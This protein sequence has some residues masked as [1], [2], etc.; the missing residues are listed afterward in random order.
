MYMFLLHM[1][2][3]K[4][5][6][7][8]PLPYDHNADVESH[9]KHPINVLNV[10]ESPLGDDHAHQDEDER[11]SKVAKHAPESGGGGREGGEGEG[12]QGRRERRQGKK[13]GEEGM[14]WDRVLS[15]M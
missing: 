12:R 6:K 15:V 2:S 13:R 4:Q 9:H 10:G 14:G 7:G 1:S 11:V 3:Q 5:I 8:E